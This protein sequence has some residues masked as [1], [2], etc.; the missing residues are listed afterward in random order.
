MTF[1][2]SL[3][4]CAAAAALLTGTA[5]AAKTSSAAKA[6]VPFEFVVSGK[7]MPAGHYIISN[8]DSAG[9]LSVRAER[10]STTALAVSTR[11]SSPISRP[12]PQLIF[13]RKGG[14]LHLSQVL[15]QHAQ[16]GSEFSVK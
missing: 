3:C 16:G 15:T 1:L 13:V 14:K 8:P 4:V 2:R 5:T 11:V 9:V 6:Y 10:G 7:T 12:A